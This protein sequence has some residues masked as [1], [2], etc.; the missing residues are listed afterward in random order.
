MDKL[1]PPQSFGVFK[2]VG[3]VVLSLPSAAAQQQ[4]GQ[5]IAALGLPAE[6]VVAYSA[7]EMAA[8]CEAD[9]Q[10]ASPLAA[11]GQDLNLVKAYLDM[12][13]MGYQFL[14]VK[15]ADD[16]QA[17]AVA[18]AAAAQ[19]ADRAVLY[20]SFVIEELI[21]HPQDEQQVAESPDRGLDAQTPS[22]LE[23]ERALRPR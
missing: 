22:G 7:A 9:L 3:H 8:Q 10:T 19:G 20:G 11:V 23:Q 4:A 1:N 15:I 6:Q 18:D 17:R 5:A 16:A 12:A 14:V 2:P 21:E 13:R